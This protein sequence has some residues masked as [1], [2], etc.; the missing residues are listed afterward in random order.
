MSHYISVSNNLNRNCNPGLKENWPCLQMQNYQGNFFAGFIPIINRKPKNILCNMALQKT[1]STM[2]KW[3]YECNVWKCNRIGML[4]VFFVR[5]QNALSSMSCK[6]K[7]V[8]RQNG[9]KGIQWGQLSGEF[10]D[11][12]VNTRIYF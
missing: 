2:E 7:V 10:Y 3:K 12:L 4:I 11:F 1:L 8:W 6:L 5:P 9:E